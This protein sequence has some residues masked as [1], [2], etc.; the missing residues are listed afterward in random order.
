MT[1]TKEPSKA[2]MERMKRLFEKSGLPVKI[3]G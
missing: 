3:G 1:G 2:S